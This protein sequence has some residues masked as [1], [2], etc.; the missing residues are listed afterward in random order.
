MPAAGA[1]YRFDDVPT[2]QIPDRADSTAV[3]DEGQAPHHSCHA[4]APGRA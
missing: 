2:H 4:M 1:V 3:S